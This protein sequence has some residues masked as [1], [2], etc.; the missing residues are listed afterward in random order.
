M[1]ENTEY[2]QFEQSGAEANVPLSDGETSMQ[3]K[4]GLPM[5]K[6][7]DYGKKA[8]APLLKVVHRYQDEITPYLTA[9]SRGLQGGVDALSQE[10]ANETDK[11]VAG[12]FREAA[13]G[14]NE[15]VTILKS[16]NINDLVS[17]IET[18]AQKR[19]SVMFTS[20]YLTGLFFGRISKHIGRKAF[21]STAAK[22]NFNTDIGDDLNNISAQDQ[23]IH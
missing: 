4:T 2:N 19:P 6:I 8:Y 15:G 12:W 11:Y 14:L 22:N 21:A 23:S 18:Q 7:K 3:D 17:F 1:I 16:K 13:D 10:S 20:S 5:D 9:I